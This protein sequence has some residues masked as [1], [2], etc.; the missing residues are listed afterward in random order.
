MEKLKIGIV[1]LGR[2]G[3]V[4]AQ[5]IRYKIPGAELTAACSIVQ[6]HHIRR[7]KGASSVAFRHLVS[8]MRRNLFQYFRIFP[9]FRAGKLRIAH[10]PVFRSQGLLIPGPVQIPDSLKSKRDGLLACVKAKLVNAEPVSAVG[11]IQKD[12]WQSL[13]LLTKKRPAFL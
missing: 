8:V 11:E 2:L 9:F 4:H 1:G 12:F 6:L 3:R 10:Q 7:C 13:S 5:N